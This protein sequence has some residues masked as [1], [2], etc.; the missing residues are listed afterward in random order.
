MRRCRNVG[1][2]RI[3][4]ASCRLVRNSL[5]S[6]TLAGQ[7]A[8]LF[9]CVGNASCGCVRDGPQSKTQQ[10]ARLV[11]LMCRDVAAVASRTQVAVDS[12]GTVYSRRRL[13]SGH[14]SLLSMSEGGSDWCPIADGWR[15]WHGSPS[16]PVPT[17]DCMATSGTQE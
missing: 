9:G 11:L 1:R 8:L 17:H 16:R 6:S 10:V 15:H 12:S 3:G 7:A 2:R 14:S 5:R 13:H 4:D